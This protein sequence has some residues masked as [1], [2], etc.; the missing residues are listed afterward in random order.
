MYFSYNSHH[1]FLVLPDCLFSYNH[2][3]LNIHTSTFIYDEWTIFLWFHINSSTLQN[4][5]L[6]FLILGRNRPKSNKIAYKC[7][8]EIQCQSQGY[9]NK[10]N[11]LFL[12]ENAPIT[13]ISTHIS[14]YF[15]AAVCQF[16]QQTPRMNA[17]PNHEL[18]Q[19]QSYSHI[20]TFQ[21]FL[22]VFLQLEFKQKNKTK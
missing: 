22:F 5:L 1:L 21:L 10:E 14:P 6:S 2:T 18:L 9:A 12:A 8:D 19:Q 15:N 7:G 17:L 3:H 20:H 16:C 13:N 4:S 11:I